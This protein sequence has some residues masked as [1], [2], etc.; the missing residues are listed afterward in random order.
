MYLPHIN[1]SHPQWLRWYWGEDEASIRRLNSRIARAREWTIT[2]GQR[3]L[4]KEIPRKDGHTFSIPVQIALPPPH[5]TK[6]RPGYRV[7]PQ[8]RL[9]HG[10]TQRRVVTRRSNPQPRFQAW[11]AIS[12]DEIFKGP[13]YG[14]S[15]R[16]PERLVIVWAPPHYT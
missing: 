6:S 10:K 15:T 13:I 4:P 2:E 1:L 12:T 9:A 5:V 16:G 3:G 14:L 7:S 11:A 8:G